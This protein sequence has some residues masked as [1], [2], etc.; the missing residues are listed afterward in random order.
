M[1]DKILKHARYIRVVMRKY[2]YLERNIGK[3]DDDFKNIQDII[4]LTL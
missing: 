3:Q 2:G 1:F 4:R